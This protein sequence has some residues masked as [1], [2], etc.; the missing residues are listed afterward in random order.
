MSRFTKR[1]TKRKQKKQKKRQSRRR[2]RGG[3]VFGR[4]TY[5]VVLGE[6]RV[7]CENEEFIRDRIESKQEVTKVFFN[8]SS[9]KNVVD[10]L[11]LLNK[12]FTK[13]ELKD[14]N[15]YFILPENLC[16][17]NKKEMATHSSVYNDAWREG[18]DFKKHTMQT[19]SDQGK[20]DLNSELLSISNKAEIITFLKKL[21]RIIEG[22]EK[23]HN[24]H[25][26][27][28][29]LKLQ[30]VIVDIQGNFK[31]I[32]VDELRDVEKLN[33][34]AAFF[35]DNH[36]YTIWPTLANMFL[37]NYY[38]IKYASNDEFIGKTVGTLFNI[39]SSEL[40][41]TQY[42]QTLSLISRPEFSETFL[43]EKDP[44][45]YTVISDDILQILVKKYGEKPSEH[46][47]AIYT[48]IDKYSFGIILLS[49][50]KR[51]FEI[52]GVKDDDT[53]VAD[54]LEMIEQCCFLKNGLKTT[55]HHIKT[56]YI[57]FV[58]SL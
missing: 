57:K 35:Y 42:N 29:D 55:T 32:D 24:K 3:K 43:V 38:K 31:I 49:V 50:L 22:I 34:D 44:T 14:L 52:V 1:Q 16:K 37:I 9:I 2:L 25:I 39:Q 45:N 8:E 4:G 6:P 11:E 23:I 20:H 36:S 10:T 40:F 30:N 7:P 13:D 56:E 33:F 58:D 19:T 17:L 41:S 46:L 47:N 54:L 26:I 51:Y 48:F 12:S 27:H 53:L 5:G 15:K 18:T 21:R 28:G